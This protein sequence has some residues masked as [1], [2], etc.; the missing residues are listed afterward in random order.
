LFLLLSLIDTGVRWLQSALMSDIKR[1]KNLHCRGISLLSL[2]G[3]ACRELFQDRGGKIESAKAFNAKYGS[4]L[5]L[6]CFLSQKRS[7]KI[8]KKV[9]T[10]FGVRFWPKFS[11]L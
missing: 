4:S 1:N 11:D 9:T 5:K 2:P 10:G 8:K 3:K 6:N 7:L